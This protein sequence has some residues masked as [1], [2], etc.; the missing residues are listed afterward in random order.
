MPQPSSSRVRCPAIA[1]CGIGTVSALG[2]RVRVLI[3]R[4][5]SALRRLIAFLVR[6]DFHCDRTRVK[7]CNRSPAASSL[8][9]TASHFSRLLRGKAAR[10]GLGR[11]VGMDH[12]P[13]IIAR[14]RLNILGNMC[15]QATALPNP[16]APDRQRGPSARYQR[17]LKAK[18]AVQ[19][20]EDGAL[21]PAGVEKWAP[22]D[23]QHKSAEEGDAGQ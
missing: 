23:L 17:G 5:T 11:C 3:G 22:D 1:A 13:A 2:S 20:Q 12:V 18:C 4:R 8:T 21:Q 14:L 7:M 15:Q 9:A 10:L 16:T 19:N 6:A